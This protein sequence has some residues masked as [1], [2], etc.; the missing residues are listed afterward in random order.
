MNYYGHHPNYRDKYFPYSA[1]Q[2]IVDIRGLRRGAQHDFNEYLLS[3]K[4]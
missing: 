4:I 3:T 2:H 1:E